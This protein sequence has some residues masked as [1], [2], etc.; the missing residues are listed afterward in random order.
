M[1]QLFYCI[2]WA[3][4]SC[5][6][7]G[8][9]VRRWVLHAETC[10]CCSY[11]ATVRCCC[12]IRPAVV[13]LFLFEHLN[14]VQCLMFR[15][16]STYCSH[17]YGHRVLCAR[18]ACV[19]HAC[20]PASCACTSGVFAC[21]IVFLCVRL[22]DRVRVC[23]SA[24]VIMHSYSPCSLCRSAWIFSHL[25]LRA[26]VV[27]KPNSKEFLQPQIWLFCNTFRRGSISPGDS[28]T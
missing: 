16:S 1:F 27:F 13:L 17:C 28:D 5:K 7:P 22:W 2:Y 25:Q 18:Y 12:S 20:M 23:P 19:M 15:C 10:C 4:A 9:G 21:V 11:P 6:R 14:T 26:I 24:R 3:W 8:L